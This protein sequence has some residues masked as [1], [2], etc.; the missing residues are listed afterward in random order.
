[1]NKK[2]TTKSKVNLTTFYTN[3]QL[4]QI[5][6]ACKVKIDITLPTYNFV[7]TLALKVSG[8]S[9]Q[10]YMYI[11]S[12]YMRLLKRRINCIEKEELD[13]VSFRIYNAIF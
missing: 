11:C 4:L 12:H 2:N 6:C 13:T 8:K 3:Y 5:T 9:P 7:I 1:M 10:L